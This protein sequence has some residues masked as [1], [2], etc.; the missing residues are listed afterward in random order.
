MTPKLINSN[1]VICTLYISVFI[2]ESSKTNFR[3]NRIYSILLAF[4]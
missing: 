1:I 2:I 4:S 3:Q